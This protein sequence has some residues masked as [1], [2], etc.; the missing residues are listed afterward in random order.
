VPGEVAAKVEHSTPLAEIREPMDVLTSPPVE[1]MNGEADEEGKQKT[2]KRKKKD[3]EAAEEEQTETT[4]G[5]E[6]K[7]KKKKKVKTEE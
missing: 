7:K 3:T 4:D 1:P 6:K 2:K 5:A